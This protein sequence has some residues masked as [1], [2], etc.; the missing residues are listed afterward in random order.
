[1]LPHQIVDYLSL[2]G[3]TADNVPGATGVGPKGAMELL[4]QFGTVE[5]MLSN[6]GAIATSRY[7]HAVMCYGDMI[8]LSKKLV[9]IDCDVPIVDVSEMY[10]PF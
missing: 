6:P 9:T 4:K 10:S 7:R 1:V 5:A 3:D 8:R 2:V